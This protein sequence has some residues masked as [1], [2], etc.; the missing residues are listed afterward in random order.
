MRLALWAPSGMR[1]PHREGVSQWTPTVLR[2]SCVCSLA[3]RPAAPSLVPWPA[4]PS[5]EAPANLVVPPAWPQDANTI[6]T[7]TTGQ[8]PVHYRLHAA[9]RTAP[10]GAA[11][12]MMAV[13]D[14]AVVTSA[15]SARATNASPRPMASECGTCRTCNDG[16]CL[17]VANNTP[18][19]GGFCQSGAC[20]A[21][22][23]GGQPCCSGDVCFQVDCSIRGLCELCGDDAQVCCAGGVCGPELNCQPEQVCA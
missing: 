10:V 17:A 13:E 2:R 16:K 15:R 7:T 1:R 14:H 5:P 8:S 3:R 18:C 6:T 21:C 22:G 23:L 4:L 9:F 12:V 20:V 11:A 19:S